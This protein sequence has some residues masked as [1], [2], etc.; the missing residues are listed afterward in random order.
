VILFICPAGIQ[1]AVISTNIADWAY[2]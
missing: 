2:G 1:I